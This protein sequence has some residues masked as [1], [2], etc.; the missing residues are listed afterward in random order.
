MKFADQ[1]IINKPDVY[2]D[3][4]IY[5]AMWSSSE[6]CLW[7]SH[8][9]CC[10]CNCSESAAMLLKADCA[11]SF[12]YLQW[13]RRS[14]RRCK[15]NYLSSLKDL[16]DRIEK[17]ALDNLSAHEIKRL[18]LGCGSALDARAAQVTNLLVERGIEI[19][20]AL[21]LNVD[22]NAKTPHQSSVSVY[23]YIDDKYAAELFF[24]LGF[25][26]I[27]EL[28]GNGFSPLLSHDK[29]YLAYNYWIVDHG[30]N[31]LQRLNPTS[32]WNNLNM[33]GAMSAHY[34]FHKIGKY[35]SENEFDTSIHLDYVHYLNSKVFVVNPCDECQC[36]CSQRGCTPF[37]A[38]LKSAITIS[39]EC[40]LKY[41]EAIPKIAGKLCTYLR[42][43]LSD[44]QAVYLEAAVR[45]MT[46]IT[47]G[48]RHTCCGEGMNGRPTSYSVDEIRYIEEEQSDLLELLEELVNEFKNGI[49]G[50][51]HSNHFELESVIS[52]WEGY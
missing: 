21:M 38:L 19:L 52:F 30:A 43:Y 14:T 17:L 7:R 37:V 25:R 50:I 15:A 29:W 33:P 35:K 39:V 44:L 5:Y 18:S 6:T 47:L 23:H 24:K 9:R 31:V 13:L 10:K 28:D 3:T 42:T 45:Y 40:R 20:P 11:T 26:D 34:E 51:L 32:T 41:S 22:T 1:G 27:D 36:S 49:G 4:A 8:T 48:L 16:R 12:H 2:G 46:F